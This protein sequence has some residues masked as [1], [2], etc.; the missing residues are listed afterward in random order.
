MITLFNA[1]GYLFTTTPFVYKVVKNEELYC[2]NGE[3]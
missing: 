1:T 3:K 2:Q